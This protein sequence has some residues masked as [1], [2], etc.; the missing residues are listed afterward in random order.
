MS[1]TYQAVYDAVRS[2]ISNADVGRAI[3]EG[4][5]LDGSFAIHQVQLA[6]QAAADDMRRPSVLFRPQLTQDGDMFIAL[7]G[8][9]L[10]VGV[11]GT[12]RTPDEAMWAFDKAWSTA[13]VAKAETA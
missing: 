7:Y 3:Q 6:F 9:D 10:A 4:M 5:H 12:G 13:A 2:R 11:V 8:P 1:D